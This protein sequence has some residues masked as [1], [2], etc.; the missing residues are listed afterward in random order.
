[1]LSATYIDVVVAAALH[2]RCLKISRPGRRFKPALLVQFFFGEQHGPRIFVTVLPPPRR[3]SAREITVL[4]PIATVLIKISIREDRSSAK[5]LPARSP[6]IGPSTRGARPRNC[7]DCRLNESFAAVYQPPPNRRPKR[8]FILLLRVAALRNRRNSCRQWSGSTARRMPS[9]K[10]ETAPQPEETI[11]LASL[12]RSAWRAMFWIFKFPP[13]DAPRGVFPGRDPSASPRMAGPP[14]FRSA[15]AVP[16]STLRLVCAPLLGIGLRLTDPNYRHP[17]TPTLLN[18]KKRRTALALQRL[19]GQPFLWPWHWCV[20]PPPSLL[21]GIAFRRL[22]Q[23]GQVETRFC[24]TR[25]APRGR[26]SPVFFPRR[27]HAQP[28]PV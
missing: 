2:F 28:Q 17:E 24:S 25:Q 14:I 13:V 10:L 7:H 26:P 8:I 15:A 11:A 5:P 18:R 3:K 4:N 27:F 12:D 21:R 9:P 23:L 22:Q 6:R 1:V 19:L 16:R 20:M